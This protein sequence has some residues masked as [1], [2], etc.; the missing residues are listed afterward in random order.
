MAPVQENRAG[1]EFFEEETEDTEDQCELC[2]GKIA[3]GKSGLK[4]AES[5]TAAAADEGCWKVVLPVQNT[6]TPR[7]PSIFVLKKDW[8]ELPVGRLES[9]SAENSICPIAG[10]W[11]CCQACSGGRS[12]FDCLRS[13]NR[14]LF[15]GC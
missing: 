2:S 8:A 7:D 4:P 3:D 12:E 9:T 14:L 15:K 10:R 5:V 1:R 11:S 13:D 6:L